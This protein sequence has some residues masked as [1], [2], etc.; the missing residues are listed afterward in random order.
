[1]LKLLFRKWWILLIQGILLIILAIYIFNNPVDVLAGLSIWIGVLVFIAGVAG[2]VSWFSSE[3]AERENSTLLWSLITLLFGLLLLFNLLATMKM[4]TVLFGLWMLISGVHLIRLGLAL[5]RET[6]S[7]L[8]ILIIGVLAALA[9]I[10]TIFNIGTGAI[11]IS[12]LLG[13]QVL[14]VG[15]EKIKDKLAARNG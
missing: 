1:M 7:G 8:F 11:A 6:S 3:K 15:I 14:L 10:A 2:L 12:V 9:A 4:L 5:R 13:L